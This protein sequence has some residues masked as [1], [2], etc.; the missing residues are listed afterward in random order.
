MSIG[1][2]DP[3]PLPGQSTTGTSQSLA[4]PQRFF[5]GTRALPCPYVAGRIERKVV[6]D[7]AGPHSQAYYERLSRAGFRR[8]HG[9][10]YR[11]A[12]P[13]CNAC[14]PVRIVVGDLVR[15]R[16]LRRTEIRNASLRRA[17]LTALATM[18][19]YRLFARY[20]RSRHGGGDMAAMTFNDFRAM[21]EE[22]PIDSRIIEYREPDGRLVGA[23]LADRLDNSYSA[24]YSFF[25]PEMAG[26]GIGTFMILDLVAL[27]AAESRPYVYLGYWIAD[28]DKMAYKTRFRPLEQLGPDGW[29]PLPG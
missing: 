7:L 3:A 19:Q 21:V 24:V 17:N 8:S 22:T 18:E 15:N 27:A 2:V 26:R 5:F 29:G 25:D 12:C 4:R 20:Q 9:L 6:T 16:S 11:P 13:A 28:S 1:R 14:V 23:M 10:A